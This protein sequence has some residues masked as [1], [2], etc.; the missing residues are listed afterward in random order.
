MFRIVGE[1]SNL[2]SGS[3]TDRRRYPSVLVGD[4][5][6]PAAVPRQKARPKAFASKGSR[7]SQLKI[8]VPLLLVVITLLIFG[9]IMVYSASYDYSTSWYGNPTTI[10]NRQLIWLVIGV[11]V[12]LGL[13]FT[14]YHYWKHLAVPADSHV[15]GCREKMV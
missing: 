2:K 3:R 11:C 13:T 5:R 6:L 1:K 4:V 9:L 10:F 12:A 8:D 15:K 14:D 7:V